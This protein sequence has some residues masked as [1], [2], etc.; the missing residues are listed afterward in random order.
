MNG[1]GRTTAEQVHA[2]DAA[3]VVLGKKGKPR[4]ARA[5]REVKRVLTASAEWAE[6][7]PVSAV[8]AFRVEFDEVMEDLGED[9]Q[10]RFDQIDEAVGHRCTEA[11][12]AAFRANPDP[13]VLLHTLMS[14]Q[15]MF[16]LAG[17]LH[18]ER[19]YTTPTWSDAGPSDPDLVPDD[20][21]GWV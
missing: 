17:R 16:F 21:S 15:L 6:P 3:I 7:A 14:Q 12:F 1:L 5:L 9:L 19:G 18:A 10:H 2:L 13:S 11:L 4:E 8:G 20:L